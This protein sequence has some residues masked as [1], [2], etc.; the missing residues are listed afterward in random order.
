MT[1]VLIL[2]DTE[3][4]P[5]LRHEVPV[6]I[7]DP[8]IYAEAGG[9][10]HAIVSSL[11]L[12]RVEPLGGGLVVHTF[13]EYG[14][15]ALVSGGATAQELWPALAVN[16]AKALGIEEAVVPMG[17]PLAAA[18]GL[19]AAGIV[20]QVDQRHF[21]DRRRV[22]NSAE[23]EGI[24]RASRAVEAGIEHATGMLRAAD[25]SDDGLTL[26]GEPLT[27]ERIKAELERIFAEHGAAADS[28]TVS[29]GAQTA[30][31]HDPGSGRIAANDVVLFDLYPRDRETGCYTD[32]SRTLTVGEPPEEV[33]EF[34][35]LAKEALDL[36]V[37]M[38]RP[39]VEGKEIHRAVCDFFHEHG[40]KTQLHKEPGEILQDGYVHAT[41]HGVG[42]EVHEQPGVGRTGQAL[43][44]GDVIAL[45]PGLYRSG[46]YGVRLEDLVLVTKDGCE[47][48]THHPYGLAV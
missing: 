46:H 18:D 14:Y 34:H 38:V 21:D 47:L 48:L 4:S 12:A 39:G 30:I 15:E 44:A 10:R 40:Q 8:L 17:F 16:V 1:D 9:A 37:G 26:D 31:G 43:V 3:R 29:H 23:L 28:F 33:V 45:E 22:K 24:R 5:E 35:R 25:R 41:G 11:E 2:G 6:E 20:L 32:F 13:E 27:C 36:A 19:R 7:G 42:L